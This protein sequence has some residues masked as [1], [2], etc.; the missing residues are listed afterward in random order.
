MLKFIGQNCSNEIKIK[1][2]CI[3]LS[4]GSSFNISSKYR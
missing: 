2:Q 4:T 3:K 1:R